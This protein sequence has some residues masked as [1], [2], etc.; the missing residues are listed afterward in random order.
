MNH[1]GDAVITGDGQ[2]VP[3]IPGSATATLGLFTAKARKGPRGYVGRSI[4]SN[5]G[6]LKCEVSAADGFD[7]EGW[8]KGDEKTIRFTDTENSQEWVYPK[9]VLIEDPEISD[10][11]ESKWSLSFEG[12]SAEK[13]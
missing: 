6:T 4:H 5:L 13:V 9:M 8:S 1:F 2:E 11:E 7:P 3:S 12:S 10:G